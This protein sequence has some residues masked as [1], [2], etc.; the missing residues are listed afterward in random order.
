MSSNA[1]MSKRSTAGAL[2]GIGVELRSSNAPRSGRPPLSANVACRRYA[3]STTRGQSP[4][5]RAPEENSL[6]MGSRMLHAAR[7]AASGAACRATG[8][9]GVGWNHMHLVRL[10]EHLFARLARSSRHPLQQ[11]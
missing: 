10:D 7:Q 9:F 5:L 8:S 6:M 1:T 2:R 3:A 4:L 11:L